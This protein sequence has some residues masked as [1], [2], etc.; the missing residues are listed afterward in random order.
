MC[1]SRRNCQI[2]NFH[3]LGKQAPAQGRGKFGHRKNGSAALILP[4]LR[5]RQTAHD[6]ASAHG[7][8]GIIAQ[9]ENGIVRQ[10][11][12]PLEIQGRMQAILSG[13]EH[14]TASCCSSGLYFSY[15]CNYKCMRQESPRKTSK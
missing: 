9:N 7:D 5:E 3:A 1:T 12:C 13:P 14:P 4:G 8:I 10:I 6:M 2:H 15:Q 11:G